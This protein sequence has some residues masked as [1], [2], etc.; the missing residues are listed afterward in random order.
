MWRAQSPAT[1]GAAMMVISTIGASVMHVSVRHVSAELPAVEIAFFRNFLGLVVLSPIFL[2]RG[3]TPFRT[4][5]IGLHAL[6][7]VINICA[8]LMF[9]VALSVAPLAKVTALNFAAPIFA[10]ILSALIL[11]EK[12]R[13]RRWLAIVFG[14]LGML[15]IIRPGFVEVDAGS[16][17]AI[18]AALL[19]GIAVILIKILSRTE[20][21]VTIVVWMGVFLSAFSFGPALW[22]W[23]TPTPE[24]FLW[25]LFMAFCGTIA[26]VSVSEALKLAEPT[27]ILPLDFL[28]LVWAALIGFWFFAEIPDRWTFIGAGVIFASAVYVVRQERKAAAT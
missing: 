9:F 1:R 17:L 19:W 2:R 28:K 26:Q 16:L 24:T 13:A 7:G 11:R 3:L 4:R 25:L 21:S 5:R 10:A 20:S 15:T 6:R 8:M 22:V 27:A 18:A 12:I 23:V 14:F